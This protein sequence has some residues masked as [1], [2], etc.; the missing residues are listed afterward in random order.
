MSGKERDI[1]DRRALC[2]DRLGPRR[3]G[4]F[5]RG[6]CD[7]DDRPFARWRYWT[8]W[9]FVTDSE[10]PISGVVGARYCSP[11]PGGSGPRVERSVWISGAVSTSRATRSRSPN[12]MR[13]WKGSPTES[14]RAA[15]IREAVRVLEPGG[16]LAVADIGTTDEYQRLLTELTLADVT[17]RDQGWRGWWGSQVGV[18]LLAARSTRGMFS[19]GFSQRIASTQAG[20][21]IRLARR[22]I[23]RSNPAAQF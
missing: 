11:Q 22:S 15:A 8:G 4:G 10:Y 7:L 18:R 20:T 14:G 16:R 9:I 5:G 2:S 3:P 13:L 17:C 19:S 23:P 6:S 12:V 1:R 21:L